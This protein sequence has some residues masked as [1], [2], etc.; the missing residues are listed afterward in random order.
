VLVLS[1]FGVCRSSSVAAA[2]ITALSRLLP[3]LHPSDWSNKEVLVN[4]LYNT[5]LDCCCSAS[6][7]DSTGDLAA[8]VVEAVG[9]VGVML[10][11]YQHD[12]VLFGAGSSSNSSNNS[13]SSSGST[14]RSL[15]LGCSCLGMLLSC[16]Q[17][18]WA[19][20]TP[21]Q[22]SG[23][24]SGRSLTMQQAVSSV[25]QQLPASCRDLVMVQELSFSQVRPLTQYY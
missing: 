17:G 23:Q 3:V 4:V 12:D 1:S 22:T 11:Q 18:L 16:L 20:Q 2:A 19:G 8:A 13:S 21:C 5:L 14:D 15:A 6:S 9:Y 10:L 24:T 7:S 25:L